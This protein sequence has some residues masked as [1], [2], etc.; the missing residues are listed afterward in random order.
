MGG[1][2]GSESE[3]QTA[4]AVGGRGPRFGRVGWADEFVCGEI[5]VKGSQGLEGTG[6]GRDEWVRRQMEP[7]A[8]DM[9]P[10]LHWEPLS[11]PAAPPLL[12]RFPHL[13]TALVPVL[14]TERYWVLMLWWEIRDVGLASIPRPP[15]LLLPR[16]LLNHGG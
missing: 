14:C 5:Q 13:L 9:G 11:V 16:A 8:C 10:G 4:W 15:L 2:G 1:H 3:G 6:S 7:A 12:F